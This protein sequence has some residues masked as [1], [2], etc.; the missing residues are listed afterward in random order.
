MNKNKFEDFSST[1]KIYQRV[2]RLLNNMDAEDNRP[3][4]AVVINPFALQIINPQGEKRLN[5]SAFN[6]N[7]N[8][9]SEYTQYP[10]NIKKTVTS[11]FTPST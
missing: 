2:T 5:K 3:L 10:L 9:T 11:N 8:N 7:R 4:T 1:N 6:V